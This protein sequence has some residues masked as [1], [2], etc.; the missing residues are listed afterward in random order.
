[1]VIIIPLLFILILECVIEPF[2]NMRKRTIAK[3]GELQTG[4]A[5]IFITFSIWYFLTAQFPEVDARMFT[6]SCIG[7]LVYF[8]PRKYEYAKKT[9]QE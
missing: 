2:F 7:M 3:F 8:I 1:M 5:L 4:F 6:F 9:S